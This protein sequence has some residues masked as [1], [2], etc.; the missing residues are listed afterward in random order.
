MT[1]KNRYIFASIAFIT[2]FFFA[3]VLHG[4]LHTESSDST[5]CSICLHVTVSDVPQSGIETDVFA[6]ESVEILPFYDTEVSVFPHLPFHGRA[7]PHPI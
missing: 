2:L 4:M 3:F 1:R 7:P 6:S 5:N